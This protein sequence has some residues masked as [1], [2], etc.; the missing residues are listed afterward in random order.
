MDSR[1]QGTTHDRA[2]AVAE[3]GVPTLVSASGV[4]Y[5]GNPG[6]TV[7]DEDSPRGTTYVADIAAAWEASTE[8]AAAGGAR[9]VLA[10]TGGG[11]VG[12]GRRLRAGCCRCSGSGSAASSA[13]AGSGGRGSRWTTTSAP[14]G[15]CSTTTTWPAR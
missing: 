4:G 11:A 15:S 12:Q 10:R 9:V 3:H 7:L 8:P 13:P 14:S 6:D 2:G 5:Y 1:V